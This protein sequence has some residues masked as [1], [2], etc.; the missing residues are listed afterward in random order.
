[1]L[2][3][4]M[5]AERKWKQLGEVVS[6]AEKVTFCYKTLAKMEENL[7]LFANMKLARSKTINRP[8]A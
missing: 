3:P 8:A 1:M 6:G 4:K 7:T 5:K 2:G